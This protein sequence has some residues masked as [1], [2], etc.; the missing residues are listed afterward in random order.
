MVAVREILI[1]KDDFPDGLINANY[2]SGEIDTSYLNG[3]TFSVVTVGFTGAIDFQASWDHGR[4]WVNASYT[5]RG[6]AARSDAQLAFT[7]DT[8]ARIYALREDVPLVRV[9]ITRSAGAVRLDFYGS[10]N[11]PEAVGGGVPTNRS[12]TI[13]TGGVA[14]QV[15]AANA[16]RRYLFIQN[17]SDTAMWFDIG[18]TAVASQPSTYLAPGV[19]FMWA[20]GYIPTGAVSI[21]CAT[22]GKGFTAKEG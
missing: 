3:K 13:T 4:N 16:H 18:A 9:V 12:G 7:G 19:A 8:G 20:V 11:V 17:I 14:Q 2:T 5:Q 1:G 15:M 22:T 6:S 10:Q 21:I